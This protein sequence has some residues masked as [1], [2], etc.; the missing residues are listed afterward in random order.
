MPD[1]LSSGAGVEL[2][3]D[4]QVENVGGEKRYKEDV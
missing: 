1:P 2:A 4:D 3:D